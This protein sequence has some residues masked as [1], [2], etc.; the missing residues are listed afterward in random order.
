MAISAEAG[1]S[2]LRSRKPDLIIMDVIMPGEHG[3]TATETL[4]GERNFADVP[5]V[6]FSSLPGRWAETT[7]TREDMLSAAAE[8]FIDKAKGPRVL[9]EAV[10]EILQARPSPA[11]RDGDR[12]SLA[13]DSASAAAPSAG[14]RVGEGKERG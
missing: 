2:A 4:K 3:F 6:I 14:R 9:I 11:Q 12:G 13:R 5:V 7:A 10:R 1:M 8:V